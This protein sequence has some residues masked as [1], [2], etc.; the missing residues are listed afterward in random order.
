[1][2]SEDFSVK[3]L[4]TSKSINTSHNT[5]GKIELILLPSLGLWWRLRPRPT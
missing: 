1:V 2:T 5:A 3:T 4:P